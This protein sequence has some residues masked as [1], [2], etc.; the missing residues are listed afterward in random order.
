MEKV[1]V[2]VDDFFDKVAKETRILNREFECDSKRA[3][4]LVKMKLV[5][6]I[7]KKN[8]KKETDLEEN[9]EEMQ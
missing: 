2:I 7:K 1:K 4:K 6:I 5:E 3:D 9:T 8:S